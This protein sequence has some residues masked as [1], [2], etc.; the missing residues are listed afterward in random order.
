M[1]AV[2][3]GG[4]G[5][6]QECRPSWIDEHRFFFFFFYEDLSLK[7]PVDKEFSELR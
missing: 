1:Q 5:N 7:I 2:L 6:R 3:M 4:S